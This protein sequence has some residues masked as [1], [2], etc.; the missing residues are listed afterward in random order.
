MTFL[1]IYEG[2]ITGNY[3]YKLLECYLD[4]NRMGTFTHNI[5]WHGNTKIKVS[6]DILYTLVCNGQEDIISSLQA[7]EYVG[8]FQDKQKEKGY[9][10]LENFGRLLQIV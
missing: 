4:G 6:D 7:M 5:T 1:R 10:V 9:K 2:S 3:E 8:I